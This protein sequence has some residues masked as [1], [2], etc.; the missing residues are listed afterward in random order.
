M[1]GGVPGWAGLGV[2]AGEGGIAEGR[3]VLEE[4]LPDIE[5]AQRD[6]AQSRDRETHSFPASLAHD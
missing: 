2:E 6:S 4:C 3:G 1:R 5:R